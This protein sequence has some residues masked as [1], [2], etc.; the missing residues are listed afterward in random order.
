MGVY[1]LFPDGRISVGGRFRISHKRGCSGKTDKRLC[2]SRKKYLYAVSAVR[3]RSHPVYRIYGLNKPDTVLDQELLSI[4][5]EE[6]QAFFAGQKTA[7]KTA[8]IIQRRASLY[9]A[10]NQ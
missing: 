2:S 10:E 7:E 3:K 9:M 5:T 4:I 8:E 6:S 1:P